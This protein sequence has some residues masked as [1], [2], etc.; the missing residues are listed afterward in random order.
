MKTMEKK[1]Y[2]GDIDPAKISLG[3]TNLSKRINNLSSH[4]K[5]FRDEIEFW[6]DLWQKVGKSLSLYSVH[7]R[8]P[9]CIEL[10]EYALYLQRLKNDIKKAHKQINDIFKQ[11]GRTSPV[12]PIDRSITKKI[13]AVKKELKDARDCY[14]A[15]RYTTRAGDY[16]T[17]FEVYKVISAL[18]YEKL[19]EIKKQLFHCNYLINTWLEKNKNYLILVK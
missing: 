19:L 5:Y 2:I 1:F 9:I 4:S 6:F 13:E 17:I 8:K 7:L 3:H 12:F 16:L 11:T 15:H 14:A 10:Y 18:S